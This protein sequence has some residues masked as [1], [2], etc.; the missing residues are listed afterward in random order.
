MRRREFI[1]LISGAAVWPLLARAQQAA[2]P[3]IGFLSSTSPQPYTGYADA[4]RHGL[5]E[6]GYVEGQNVVIEYRWAEGHYDRLPGM[7]S[8]LV[9]RQ[10][11]VIVATGGPPAMAAKMVNTI[12]VVFAVG[13]DPISAGLVASLNRPGGNRTGV[14]FFGV[15]LVAKRLELLRELVPAAT[16]IAILLNPRNSNA[17][18]LAGDARE[19]ARSVHQRIEIVRAGSD[20]ELDSAFEKVTELR[21]GA[22]LV[23]ADPF[24][25]DRRE[26]LVARVAQFRVPANYELREFASAGGLMSYGASLGDSYRQVG[27]YAGRILKGEKPADL[28]VVQPTKFE[29]VINLKTAKELGLTVPPPLLARADEVIE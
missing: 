4:F 22:L 25:N 14:S 11:A 7:V 10:V 21:A 3:V 18:E 15:S 29:L 24:F 12:P 16:V 19:A 2:I 6:T 8:D 20:A 13:Y 26:Q 5:A 9:G 23:G 27:I 17:D 28:P 1:A